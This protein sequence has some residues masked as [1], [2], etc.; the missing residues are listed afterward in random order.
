MAALS[1]LLLDVQ[2]VAKR[3]GGVTAL[4]SVDLAVEHGEV[5]AL[6]GENG[7]GKSTL[8]KI[9]SGALAAD[10]GKLFLGGQPYR[11]RDPLVAQRAGVA[12]IHQELSLAPDL[13]VEA[14]VMLGRELHRGFI[15]RRRVMRAKV[16]DVLELLEHAD[17][18]PQEK[19]QGLRPAARQ[20][21]ELARALASDARLI[22]MDEPSSSL[23]HRD[24]EVLFEV[25]ARLRR[26]GVSVIYISHALEELERVAD[27][28]TVL[29]DGR[30][31]ASGEIVGT[32]RSEIIAAMV[33]RAL[34]EV[35]PRVPHT[36]G[37]PVLELTGLAGE[38]LPRSTTLQLR[39]GE[40]FGIAGLVGAGRSELL[41]TLFGLDPIKSGRVLVATRHTMREDFGLPPWERLLQGF[42]LLSEARKEEGLALDHSIV[43]NLT[44]PALT[45]FSRAGVVRRPQQQAATERWCNELGVRYGDPHAPV[46]T[47]SGG[48]QQKIALARLLC[49]D[50]EVFLLDEPTRGID[51]GSKVEIYRRIT[52]LARAGKAVLM[53]SSYLPELFGVCDTLAVMRR[54]RLGTARPVAEWTEAQVMQEATGG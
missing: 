47:L 50:A 46:R 51:V 53:V 45:Q 28:F 35:Y 34:D 14:N 19:V 20:L 52:E 2:Q 10:S 26:R 1:P 40:I 33:G 37:S 23:T 24:V 3:F 18:R 48:N 44:L 54:G 11:P 4:Q 39:R 25:I 36:L 49:C 17:I 29:R 31:V 22:I 8:M 6:V 21:V 43:D 7:A 32:S 38:H 15:L 30:S 9:L 5:H 27:R 16:R 42:G 13:S 41:R 12:M